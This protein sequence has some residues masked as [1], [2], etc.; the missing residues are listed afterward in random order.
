MHFICCNCFIDFFIFHNFIQAC[1]QINI[2][3][4]IHWPSLASLLKY[5]LTC[6]M[7]SSSLWN[8]LPEHV[9]SFIW[10]VNGIF[11]VFSWIENYIICDNCIWNFQ[12]FIFSVWELNELNNVLSLI[13]EGFVCLEPFWNPL[14]FSWVMLLG[15]IE[16]KMNR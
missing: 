7:N 6:S 16:I 3:I 12:R 15:N 1:Y 8:L 9:L 5:F 2:R 4:L 10:F 13:T 14:L 11:L